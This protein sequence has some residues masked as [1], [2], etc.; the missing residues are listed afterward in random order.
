MFEILEGI[1][2]S[3]A[4]QGSSRIKYDM[5]CFRI[6]THCCMGV[7]PNPLIA[8]LKGHDDYPWYEVLHSVTVNVFCITGLHYRILRYDGDC[9]RNDL[10]R[11]VCLDSRF[12]DRKQVSVGPQIGTL[13]VHDS[14]TRFPEDTEAHPAA[15][16]S[17]SL[18]DVGRIRQGFPGGDFSVLLPWKLGSDWFTLWRTYNGGD[19]PCVQLEWLTSYVL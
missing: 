11:A 16:H 17:V 12:T 4:A 7:G 15:V 5:F 6:Q 18:I 19:T 9:K 8:A 10:L 13:K 3:L 1:E 14:G 2:G